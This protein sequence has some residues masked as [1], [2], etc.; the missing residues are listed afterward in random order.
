[1]GTCARGVRQ[2]PQCRFFEKI[3]F[4]M[5][6]RC[7]STGSPAS[8]RI[9]H[10]FS[11][12]ARYGSPCS[13][14]PSTVGARAVKT[15]SLVFRGSLN[16]RPCVLASLGGCYV[17][18]RGSCVTASR[19]ESGS[20][21]PER[22]PS[23]RA[24]SPPSLPGRT[25]ACGGPE[26]L[27][28][29]LL[30]PADTSEAPIH[31]EAETTSRPS[32]TEAPSPLKAPSPPTA[33]SLLAHIQALYASGPYTEMLAAAEEASRRYEAEGTPILRARTLNLMGDAARLMGDVGG[34]SA[35]LLR[36]RDSPASRRLLHVCPECPLTTV[37]ST[38]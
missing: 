1:M 13:S 17:W 23:G 32:E 30:P 20:G 19:G 10:P 22:T 9:S 36:V 28:I 26:R 24:A 4:G 15:G 5:I 21:A 33:D 16:G 6:S 35:Y 7:V 31:T 3:S 2:E 38:I 27:F 11:S 37:S 18:A 12:A 8:P 25:P 14:A 34:A 29:V